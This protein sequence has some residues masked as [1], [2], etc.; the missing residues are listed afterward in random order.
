MFISDFLIVCVCSYRI[1]NLLIV[2]SYLC[3]VSC[4]FVV[5]SYCIYITSYIMLYNHSSTSLLLYILINPWGFGFIVNTTP[6]ASYYLP[7]LSEDKLNFRCH[8]E[9]M[10]S[11]LLP[12]HLFILDH[13]MHPPGMSN[14]NDRQGWHKSKWRR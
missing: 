8:N 2:V 11:S 7:F 14:G 4:S 12:W 9:Q 5:L 13:I 1:S 3:I 6:S 10:N